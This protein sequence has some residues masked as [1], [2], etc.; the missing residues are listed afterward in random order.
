MEKSYLNLSIFQAKVDGQHHS[1]WLLVNV[2]DVR[3]FPCQQLN[4]DVWSNEAVR[5]IIKERFVLWQV[6]A[7]FNFYVTSTF[8][9]LL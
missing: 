9:F 8:V 5:N 3:E 4:R 1:K 7:L 2:Q 6:W